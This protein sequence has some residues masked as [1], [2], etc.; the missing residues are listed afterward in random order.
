MKINIFGSTGEIGQKTLFIIN[1]YFPTIR[2]NLLVAKNNYK[3]L[4]II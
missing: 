3:K 2:V 1:K 4:Q